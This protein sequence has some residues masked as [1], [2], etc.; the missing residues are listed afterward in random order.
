[1][2]PYLNVSLK[3]FLLGIFL[4]FPSFCFCQKWVA[5]SI[6]IQ[7]GKQEN[8]EGLSFN[9]SE[10]IDHRIIFP[11]FI[12]VFERKKLL[13]F[14]VDQVVKTTKP[15]AYHFEQKF[16]TD[17]FGVTNYITDIHD[18]TIKNS[19][20]PGK[21]TLAL[22]A[23]IELS[24][25]VNDRDTSLVGTFYYERSFSH[26]K[27]QDVTDGYEQL[28]EKWC[29]QYAS[30]ILSVEEDIDLKVPD[31][32]YYFRRGERA[33]KKNFYI[34]ADLFAGLNFW[35]VDGELWFSEP[36]GNRIFNRNSTIIRYV[37]HPTFQ[38]I[39]FG[40]N[41]RHWN[42]RINH[43]WLF[44]N[45]MAMLMGVNNWKD[46]DTANHKLEEI[47]F[48]NGSMNQRFNFNSLDKTGVVF[49]IGIMEDL[50]YIIYHRVGFNI[51]AS[52]NCAYKF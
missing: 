49:G 48:F 16:H 45:K 14:P 8:I 25:I 29:Q 43:N 24:E 33:V 26:K 15:L 18:F 42:Y 12:S 21:R 41:L 5:D 46:M 9:I 52:V 36:E 23:T 34:S 37:N 39:A 3:I 27:K 47:L 7:F 32:L 38:A 4:I 13:F 30:D 51:G 44:T 28:L 6:T 11:E 20:S 10:A 19:S 31:L 17:S 40:S 2:R 50:H 35:G 22:F 1:M